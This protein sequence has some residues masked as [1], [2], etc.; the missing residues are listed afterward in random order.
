MKLGKGEH[1]AAACLLIGLWAG[2][3]AAASR[4]GNAL[5]NQ[6]QVD[7][8]LAVIACHIYIHAVLDVLDENAIHGY[9]VCVPEN[10]DIDQSVKVFIDW[11]NQHADVGQQPASDL[12]AHALWETYPC[13]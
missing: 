13:K 5:S 10:T 7:S 3:A 6:C 9:R 8:N 11:L 12:V 2:P 1:I 4:D